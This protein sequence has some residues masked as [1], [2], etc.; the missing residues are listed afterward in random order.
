ME[1]AVT[2]SGLLSLRTVPLDTSTSSLKEILLDPYRYNY[3]DINLCLYRKTKQRLN[4][5][6]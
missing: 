3:L 1:E 6:S 2:S 5:M 4:I